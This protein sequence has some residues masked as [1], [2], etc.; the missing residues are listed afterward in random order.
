VISK[1]LANMLAKN[2]QAFLSS[3]DVNLRV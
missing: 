1:L 2:S 3:F